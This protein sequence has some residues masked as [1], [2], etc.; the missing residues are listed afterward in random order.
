MS[1][2]PLEP[3][4]GAVLDRLYDAL[5]EHY[6]TADAAGD[7]PLYR[8]LAGVCA[9]QG[10]LE[11]LRERIDFI[12][13]N[14]GGEPGDTSDLADPTTADAAWLPWLAQLV[15]VGLRADWTDAEKRDAIQYASSGWRAGTKSA[16]ADAARTELTGTKYARVYDHSVA[17]PGDGGVWDVLIVTRTTETP[18]VGRVLVAVERRGAKPA[19]VVLHHRAYEAGWATV[20]STYPTWD[21]IEAAGSWNRIQEAGL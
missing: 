1:A 19:G 6:R 13:P 21:S 3:S 8:W 20:E 7:Y 12:S 18:D 14:D 16:V 15:G 5:P 10:A 9:E 4:P 17:V 2:V 11:A